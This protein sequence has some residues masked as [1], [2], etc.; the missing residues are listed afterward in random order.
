MREKE[1][2]MKEIKNGRKQNEM[3]EI[4]NGRKP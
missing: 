1:N 2:E 3:K 4:K